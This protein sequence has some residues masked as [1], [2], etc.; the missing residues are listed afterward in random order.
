L[1]FLLKNQTASIT[2]ATI[3]GDLERQHEKREQEERRHLPEGEARD[4]TAASCRN[5]FGHDRLYPLKG[6]ILRVKPHRGVT[7]LPIRPYG[8]LVP[9]WDR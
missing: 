8:E 9:V 3:Q 2:N 6:G 7:T 5:G 1:S 4:A